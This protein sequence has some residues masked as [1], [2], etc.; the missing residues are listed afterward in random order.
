MG[1]SRLVREFLAATDGARSRVAV[2]QCGQFGERPY[3]PILDLLETFATGSAAI[4]PA[5]SRGAQLAALQAAFGRAAEKHALVG[6][7]EDFH[8]ADRG[9]AAVLELL[10]ASIER[11]RVL[12]VVTYRSDELHAG[13]PLFVPLG[14]LLRLGNVWPIAVRALNPREA[15]TLVDATLAERDEQV[16]RHVRR[17]I[18]R[19]GEGNP[20]FTEELLKDA[21]DRVR[22]RPEGETLPTTVRAAIVHRL[23]PLDERDRAVLTQAAVIGRRFDGDLLAQTLDT[24]FEELLPTLQRARRCQLVEETDEPRV[25]RFRHALTRE[26]IYEDLLVAQRRPLHQRIALAL[27]ASGAERSVEAIAYHAWASGNR[28]KAL[29]YGERAGDAALALHE[30]AGAIA[31]YERTLGLLDAGGGDA[32]RVA[33]KIGT[34]YFRSGVMDRAVEY[35]APAWN[36]VRSHPGGAESTFRLARNFG[37]ALFNDGRGSEAMAFWRDALPVVL[38]CGDARIADLARLTYAAYLVDDGH[39]EAADALL[40]A[41]DPSRV[42]CDPELAVTYWGVQCIS[43][44]LRHD[45]A[46]LH[47]AVE[48]LCAPQPGRDVL[49]PL[50]DALGEAGMAALY[51]GESA[52]ARRCLEA[53]LAACVELRSS[54]MLRADASVALAFERALAGAYDEAA[55]LHAGAMA[56]IGE[57]KVTWN[58]AHCVALLV[59]LATANATLRAEEPGADSLESAFASGKAPV[60]GPLAALVAELLIRRGESGRARKLL[61]RAVRAAADAALSLGTFPLVVVAAGACERADADLVRALA[62][63]DAF[64]GAAPQAAADLA[65]AILARRFG[66][67]NASL[68]ARAAAAFGTVGWPYFEALAYAEAGDAGAAAAIRKRIGASEPSPASG[69]VDGLAGVL[70]ARE[71]EIARLVARGRSNKEI[72]SALF[73]SVKLVEKQ[74]SSIYKKLE[75]RSRN[76]LTAKVLAEGDEDP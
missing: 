4:A 31:T 38:G 9:T 36:Y 52:C 66:E 11:R 59:G 27:E 51:V 55:A 15:A 68:A 56:L 49:G 45:R 33:A 75:I 41:V 18:A 67:A 64:R 50:N 22:G 70:S 76:Q 23:E 1:K 5:D 62:R 57:T 43:G 69:A 12:I 13:H 30:Y 65:E 7:I 14:N 73:V 10:A 19:A 74:L 63:R 17:E 61:R 47:D 34:S 26:A 54:A 46:R 71:L 39:V 25:F 3:G 44:A 32:A 8:W 60:Y 37:A 72:S 6:V 24:S 16:P 40:G 28:E 42:E 2:A 48:R 53:N 58:R 29:H 20:F 35:Y 21:V